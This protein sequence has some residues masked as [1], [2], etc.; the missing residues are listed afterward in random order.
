M[1]RVRDWTI[2]GV[3]GAMIMS[4]LFIWDKMCSGFYHRPVSSRQEG[5]QWLMMWGIF[6]LL[7][8]WFELYVLM[9]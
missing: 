7:W 8:P 5:T 3:G 6:I 4:V 1:R 2:R 9:G